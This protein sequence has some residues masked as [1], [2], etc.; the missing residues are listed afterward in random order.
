M[1]ALVVPAARARWEVR[2]V[3]TPDPGPNQVLIRIKAS[4]LCFTDVHI[5]HGAIP[6]TFPRTLGHEPALDA[7]RAR[8]GFSEL[9]RIDLEVLTILVRDTESI[10]RE[11]SVGNDVAQQFVEGHRLTHTPEARWPC[12]QR[13]LGDAEH[14]GHPCQD[15]GSK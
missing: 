10:A 9:S 3:P 11:A 2:E 13:L 12:A 4:G 14:R 6:T 15:A 1:K 8:E 7:R 5:T